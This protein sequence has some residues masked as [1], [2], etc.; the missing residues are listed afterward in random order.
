MNKTILHKIFRIS[1]FLKGIDSLFETIGGFLLLFVNP[2]LI[3]NFVRLIFQ[4]ELIEDP[5]DFIGNIL[6]NL[7]SNLSVSAQLFGAIYL[8]THGVIKLALIIGL[9]KRKL[10][11]YIAAEIVFTIFIIYQVYRFT[12]THSIFLILLTF[13]DVIIIILTWFEYKQ[14]KMQ[15]ISAGRTKALNIQK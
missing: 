3:N 15:L 1:I 14:L 6:I 12:F 4:H 2:L 5:N 7:S 13:L 9:W 11:T 8:I 10:W